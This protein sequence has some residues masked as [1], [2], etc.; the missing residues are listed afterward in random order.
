MG[1]LGD[2]VEVSLNFTVS[3]LVPAWVEASNPAL[4]SVQTGTGVGDVVG[5]AEGDG[6]GVGE[7]AGAALDSGSVSICAVDVV[8]KVMFGFPPKNALSRGVSS[9]KWPVTFTVAV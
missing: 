9:W 1:Q 6:A 4:G 2:D 8:A 3:G 5:D 7:D